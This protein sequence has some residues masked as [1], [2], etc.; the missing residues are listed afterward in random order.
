L[1][2]QEEADA[3]RALLETNGLPVTYSIEDVDA[4][5]DHFYLDKKS[6]RGAITFVLPGGRIGTH[7]RRKEIDAAVV[8]DA[9]RTFGGAR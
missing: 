9:L 8:K 6:N 1:L 3:I 7:A 2:S 4:F 5:Y